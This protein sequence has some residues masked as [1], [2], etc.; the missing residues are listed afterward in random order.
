VPDFLY[1]GG[2]AERVHRAM[3]TLLQSL[4]QSTNEKDDTKIKQRDR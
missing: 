1:C 2:D 3:V 4:L